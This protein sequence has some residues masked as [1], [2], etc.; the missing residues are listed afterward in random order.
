MSEGGPSVNVETTLIAIVLF[1]LAGCATAPSNQAAGP[2][3]PGYTGSTIVVGNNSTIA[4]DA[5]A[6]YLQQK[7]GGC[8]RC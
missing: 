2:A 4:G 5:G 7:W 8:R 1:A 6:T 3:T